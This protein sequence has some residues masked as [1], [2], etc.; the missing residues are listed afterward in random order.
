MNWFKFN[1]KYIFYDIENINL[2]ERI[3]HNLTINKKHIFEEKNNKLFSETVNI[4][5]KINIMYLVNQN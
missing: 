5:K 4:K 1:K 3:F 2:N